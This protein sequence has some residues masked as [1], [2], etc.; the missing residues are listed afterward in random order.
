MKQSL[1]MLFI[2]GLIACL[3]SFAIIHDSQYKNS[4]PQ[5]GKVY[6]ESQFKP[7]LKPQIIPVQTI[8]IQTPI[9][10]FNLQTIT[11]VVEKYITIGTEIKT[12][13]INFR[14]GVYGP[15]F[16]DNVPFSLVKSHFWIVTSD[17]QVIEVTNE[18]Y[19]KIPYCKNSIDPNIKGE[20]EIQPT[21]ISY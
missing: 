15:M 14:D 20:I 17:R 10:N 9:P 11:C 4:Q 6:P 19:G 21:P 16:A 13:T 5:L 1:I 7:A 3:L 18:Q 8:T 2:I 12:T